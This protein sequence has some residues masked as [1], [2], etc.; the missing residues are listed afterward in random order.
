MS[1]HRLGVNQV[2]VIKD[3]DEMVREGGDFIEQD[4]HNRFGRRWL[5][6]LEH[7]SAPAPTSAEFPTCCCS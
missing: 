5:G 1:A 4:R 3:K 7:A 2:V 6:G